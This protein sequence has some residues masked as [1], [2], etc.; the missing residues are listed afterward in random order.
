[1]NSKTIGISYLVHAAYLHERLCDLRGVQYFPTAWNDQP[2]FDRIR[3]IE[4]LLPDRGASLE[5]F[6]GTDDTIRDG[7]TTLVCPT[8]IWLFDYWAGDWFRLEFA[9]LFDYVFTPALDNLGDFRAVG[10]QEVHWLPFACEPAIHKDLHLERIYDVGFV[11]H[12]HNRS[13]RERVRLL[14][15]LSKRYRMNEFQKPASPEE[16]ARIYN[17]SKIVINIPHRPGCFN[18]RV[19]EGLACGALMLTP[20]LAHGQRE[21]FPNGTHLATYSSETDLFAQIDYF[22]HHETERVQIARSGQKEVLAKHT[23]RHRAEQIL[24][25]ISRNPNTRH[26]CN[27]PD[28]LA[29]CLA[30]AYSVAGR[31]DG[32]L[33]AIRC[34]P[35]SLKMRCYTLLRLIKTMWD[36][37]RRS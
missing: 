12:V 13:Q 34:N 6:L 28:V 33:R 8:A 30:T 20:E 32:L 31:P 22:L 7:L 26:R 10:C 5:F 35:M 18:M 15:E 25:V 17:Q 2:G 4:D 27:D 14:R 36:I 1:M 23:Y 3:P 16:M 24:A 9:R 37:W 19:Y 11:G 29:R 21:L